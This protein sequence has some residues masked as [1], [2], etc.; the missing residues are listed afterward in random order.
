M[1]TCIKCGKKTNHQYVLQVI[2]RGPEYTKREYGNPS[3]INTYRSFESLEFLWEYACS[4][5]IIK[6]NK[7]RFVLYILVGIMF[8]GIGEIMFIGSIHLIYSEAIQSSAVGI[9]MSLL[10]ILIGLGFIEYT[11]N[12]LL[13]V[14]TDKKIDAR[15]FLFLDDKSN[16]GSYLIADHYRAEL[17]KKYPTGY[18][19]FNKKPITKCFRDI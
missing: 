15:S 14:F 7:L 10:G 5:C 13:Y 1:G 2:G 18:F 4:K 6:N 9:G 11:H 3:K 19:Y 17:K 16:L 8:L 12:H